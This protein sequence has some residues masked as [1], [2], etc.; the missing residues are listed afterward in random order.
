MKS[1][2]IATML[3]AQPAADLNEPIDWTEYCTFIGDAAHGFM[4]LHQ[5]HVALSE[6][7]GIIVN[8]TP[9][10]DDPTGAMRALMRSIAMD[11]YSRTPMQTERNAERQ[12]AE[13]RNQWELTCWETEGE[14]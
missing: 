14:Q 12:R 1:L 11:A 2:L 5:G 3:A 13:F 10:E 4:Q 6:V 8:N 7:M 9:P